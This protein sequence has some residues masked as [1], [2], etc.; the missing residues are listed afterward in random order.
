MKKRYA[1]LLGGIGIVLL[2]IAAT[3]PARADQQEFTLAGA[4]PNDVF[5]C[6]TGKHNP[7][8][9]FLE[10]YWGEVLAE[11]KKC[12]I[13]DDVLK[14]IG[15]FMD[16]DQQ[17]E[18]DRLKARVTELIDGVDWSTLAGKEI[19]FG[20]RFP[21]AMQ[22]APG[23]VNIGPP[24]MAWLF[25]GSSD[26]AA[27]NYKGLVAILQ[28]LADEVNNAAGPETL[29][30]ET[31]NREGITMAG[32]N[33][34]AKLPGA[35][36]L[37][38]IVAVHDD[39]I[40][41]GFG[42]QIIDDV[43]GLL[44]G[45]G[46]ATAMAADPRYKSAFAKLPPAEDSMVFF[47]MQAMLKPIG[48]MMTQLAGVVAAEN[49]V[50]RNDH[51]SAEANKV[52]L[53]ALSAY[54]SGD[55][56][57]ALKLVKR[58]HEIEPKDSVLLYNLACFNALNGNKREALDCLQKSV[59]AGFYAPEK[60]KTDSDLISVREDPRFETAIKRAGQLAAMYTASDIILNSTKSGKAHELNTKAWEVYEQ[61]DYE[62]GLELVEQAYEIA[63]TDSR[64][65]Y[66]LACFHA[67]LGH[68]DKA[69]DFLNRAAEGGFYCPNHIAGDPDLA[70]IRGSEDYQRALTTAREKAAQYAPKGDDEIPVVMGLIDRIINAVG[71]L[72]YTA[73]VESTD[74]YTVKTETIAVLVEDARQRPIYP[75]L[76]GGKQL[77]RFDRYLPQ[78]TK[79]FSVSGGFNIGALYE[80]VLNTI[81]DL[82][83]KGEEALEQW[84]A[85]QTQVNLD[86]EKD[87]FGWIGD[88]FVT[89]TLANNGGSVLMISVSD[90]TAARE[91]I[92]AAIEFV[93]MMI[94]KFGAQNPGLA[95]IN[96]TSAPSTDERL[97]GF[98]ELRM[99]MS[100]EP[101]VWGTADGQLIFGT[102]AEAVSLCLATARGEHP[103]IR[104]NERA[105]S[106]AIVPAGG[107][108]NVT[109]TDQ[110]ELGAELAMGIGM[111]SMGTGM[112][113]MAIPDPDVQPIFGKIAGLLGKLTPV[114]RKI[115]F[116]KSTASCTTF[117][118]QAWHSKMVTN[119]FSPQER[120]G[121]QIP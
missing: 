59:E 84:A 25:R 41:I 39:V 62:Q 116:F 52:N 110:R 22:I 75:V 24:E 7:D 86:V 23:N 102:S 2:A 60:I 5:I 97:E 26:G 16:T 63:P 80:F 79:S 104:E 68:D 3:T 40:F 55:Y 54:Q 32:I 87:I 45:H 65:L 112:M 113:A 21:S 118:G 19:A 28:G 90:E 18:F 8:R 48:K 103:S 67:L 66:Y 35:P 117:D 77:T 96:F 51:I 14:L 58:A 72:D 38:L 92:S 49:D 31:N 111:V 57:K 56:E 17:A 30:V 42:N 11:L 82:G 119:Y 88:E 115:D 106:E 85:I 64:V 27:H 34:L 105:M 44:T 107:F 100:P 81:R 37:K 46:K 114:V 94:G 47:D 4:V 43:C 89:V 78:E 76:C 83:P 70:S 98:Q 9:K 91:K 6:V 1:L 12:G 109:L 71:I 61:K 108:T 53:E 15:S 99:M 74:G 120:A 101:L 69:L 36:P 73:A 13:G 50:Y 121:T 33:L 10:D 93:S 29:V 20:E 95:M